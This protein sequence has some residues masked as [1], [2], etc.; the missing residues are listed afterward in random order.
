MEFFLEYLQQ[1]L[2][3]KTYGSK[4]VKFCIYGHKISKNL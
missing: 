3:L 1:L 2:S 4:G